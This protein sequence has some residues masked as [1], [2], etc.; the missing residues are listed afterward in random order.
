MANKKA[1][2]ARKVEIEIPISSVKRYVGGS[3]PP[4]QKLYLVPPRDSTAYII[5]RHI[6]P[7]LKDTTPTIQRLPYYLIGWAD[8]PGAKTLIPCHRALEYVSP[9]E[10]EQWEAA[11]YERRLQ[12]KEQKAAT[13]KKVGRPRKKQASP[14][15]AVTVTEDTL[16]L[17]KRVAGPSLSTPQ[18]RR[19]QDL[20][21][22]DAGQS[23]NLEAGDSSG[24]SD[25]A[26]VQRQLLGEGGLPR[27][28][29]GYADDTDQ[30]SVDQL[31]STAPSRPAN[32]AQSSSRASSSAPISRAVPPA[33][34]H[35][36]P[37]VRPAVPMIHPAF[38]QNPHIKAPK[39][40]PQPSK[41]QPAKTAIQPTITMTK[42][43]TPIASSK[44]QR[45][46]SRPSTPATGGSGALSD[47]STKRKR[48]TFKNSP[49]TQPKEKKFKTGNGNG[50][51][52]GKKGADSKEPDPNVF[53]DNDVWV[54]KELLDDRY[55]HQKGT[56]VHYYLV[57]WEGNWPPDQNPTWEPAE[58]IQDDNLI[59]EY[60]RRKKAGLLRP[61][62]SQTTLLS[63]L[64]TPQYSN[65]AEAFEGDIH[66]Q[67]KPVKGGVESDSDE[68]D[69]EEELLVTDGTHSG[70]KAA[71]VFPLVDQK[72]PEVRGLF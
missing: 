1:L 11:D 62:K 4:M 29:A 42:G 40:T 15:P 13:V 5:T 49:A 52:K 71:P 28:D 66:D 2:R 12:E 64:T 55:V 38:L 59:A 39:S 32:L 30:D 54:V 56:K 53:E 58:N 60:R 27:V 35:T 6:L 9:A 19:H 57:N 69:E 26:A 43:F 34:P 41:S 37:T 25:E 33:L 17:A 8:K 68:S 65:V 47:A 20:Y 46:L 50:K 72:T 16:E 7:P 51:S 48:E 14:T 18:K 36:K 61:D 3:G 10:I 24:E 22:E 21:D 44:S 23:S 63:F 31:P 45:V 67:G 70:K